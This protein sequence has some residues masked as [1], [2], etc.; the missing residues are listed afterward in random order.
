MKAVGKSIML[1]KER[2]SNI[3]FPRILRLFGR[4]SSGENVRGADYLGK[5]I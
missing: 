2:G 5:K 4:I 3:I 1:K